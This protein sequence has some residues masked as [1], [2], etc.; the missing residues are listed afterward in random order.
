MTLDE[1]HAA[2]RVVAASPYVV[3]TPI[4]AAAHQRCPYLLA[5]Q[6]QQKEQEQQQQQQQEQPTRFHGVDV[7]LP[8]ELRGMELL[9]K[10]ENTQVTGSFKIRGVVNMIHQQMSARGSAQPP[11]MVTMSA[12]LALHLSLLLF[13]FFFLLF[14]FLFLISFFFFFP[15]LLS[16]FS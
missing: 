16:V 14:T 7:A 4:L 15:F 6:Q 11:P 1:I 5:Q 10:L 2:A 3:H 8:Q 13:F 12:G 9:L